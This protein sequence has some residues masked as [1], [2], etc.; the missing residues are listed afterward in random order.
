MLLYTIGDSFTY[1][2]ELEHPEQHAWPR[3]IADQLNC[4]LVNEARPGVGNEFITK[5]TILAIPK[6]KPDLVIVGWTSCSR[7]EFA[8]SQGVFDIWPAHNRKKFMRPELKHRLPL[9]D[10][11][12]RNNNDLHE[13]RRWL[14]NIILLQSFLRDKS[15]RY[16]MCNTHDNQHRYGQFYTTS[17]DLYDL[18][19][20]TKFMGWPHDG[21]VEWAYGAPKAPQGH[22]LEQG[23]KQIAEAIVKHI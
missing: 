9:I 19:D 20:H 12:T 11:I 10:Y 7:H 5:R 16:L 3:V 17:Q 23:H 15:T 22:P 1:G 21:M 18:I 14:R 4:E 8:D 13:Y 2:E 6:Y